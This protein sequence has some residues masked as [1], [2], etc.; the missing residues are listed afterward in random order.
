MTMHG[1]DHLID[2][3]A[4]L[5]AALDARDATRI[6]AATVALATAIQLVKAQDVWRSATGGREK[7][8]HAIRQSDA[9]RMRVNYLANTTRQRIDQ[10][11]QLRSGNAPTTYSMPCK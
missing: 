10:L 7:L 11:G 1:V 5:I 9:A 4:A 6:E 2:C 3:Q 8:D